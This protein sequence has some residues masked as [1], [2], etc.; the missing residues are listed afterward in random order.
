MV[1]FLKNIS[2]IK[3]IYQ[4]ELYSTNWKITLTW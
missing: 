3:T 1:L 2:N 4:A